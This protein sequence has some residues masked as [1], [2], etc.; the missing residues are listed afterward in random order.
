MVKTVIFA[1]VHSAGR[2]QMS[3]AFFNAVADPARVR[4]VAAGTEPAARVHPE[5]V[6][7]MREAGLDL[8]GAK[9]TLLTTELAS[10]RGALGDDG[11]R[12]VVPIPARPRASRLAPTGPQGATA[13]A[14]ACNSRGHPLARHGAGTGAPVGARRDV[15]DKPRVLFVCVHNAA[16]SQMAEAL[17]RKY[18][19]DRFE[20]ASAGF[21][22]TEVHPLTRAVLAEVGIDASGLHAKGS[23]EY[24]AKVAVRHAIIVCA[25]AEAECPKIYPFAGETLYWAFDDPAALE[26]SAELQLAKFRRVRDEIDARIQAWLRARSAPGVS[27]DA[28]SQSERGSLRHP[29]ALLPRPLPDALDLRRDGRR[30]RAGLLRARLHRDARRH[31]RRHDVDPDRHRPHPDDVPAPREGALRGAGQGLPQH[32]RA[33]AVARPELAHRS[34]R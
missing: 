28:R 16:R 2:S 4:A 9:P 25:Q 15:I 32:A 21:E 10:R 29:P 31:E 1:C 20:V 26:G 24:L 22:P 18:A 13:R 8:S 6:D 27:D 17:L 14:G 12:R 3:A 5:V 23:R 30:D 34:G 19:G 7:T 11:L 33:R